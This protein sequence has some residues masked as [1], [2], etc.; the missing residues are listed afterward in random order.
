VGVLWLQGAGAAAYDDIVGYGSALATLKV[1]D[2]N[3]PSKIV[4]WITGNA[5]PQGHLPWPFQWA[6]GKTDYLV[7]WGTG[8]WPTWLA[9]LPSAAWLLIRPGAGR[10]LVAAWTLCAWVQVALPGLFWQHYY[11]LPTPGLA[12]CL[13]IALGD[14]LEAVRSARRPFRAGRLLV[15]SVA[16]LGLVAAGLKT[17]QIQVRDYLMV[18][19]EELT[20]RF[21]GGRQ[22]VVLR[23]M[24]RDL[25]RRTSGIP[26]AR[27]FIWGWQSPLLIY[28]GLDDVTRHFFT[29]PLLEDYARGFHRTDPRVR[30]RVERIMSDLEAHPPTLVFVAYPAFPELLRFLKGRYVQSPIGG[31]A[32]GRPDGL[33]L[34]VDRGHYRQFESPGDQSAGSATGA[35][36]S[37]AA[38]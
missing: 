33:G 15:G 22:W 32:M 31:V 36:R 37:E 35:P 13:A 16:T 11:L 38:R 34:W 10:R 20:S 19:P 28:S 9:A 5:D 1:P 30:P 23:G 21:K 2:P 6:F 17:A 14:A 27:L 18:A 12:L 3:A 29:D 25:G 24:G 7:W 8:S 26:D 4:R